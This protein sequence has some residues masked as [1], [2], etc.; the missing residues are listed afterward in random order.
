MPAV[1]LLRLYD[2]EGGGHLGAWRIDGVLAG[3][4]A[5]H[6]EWQGRSAWAAWAGLG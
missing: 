6:A 2:W 5:C 4:P 3:A 1:V